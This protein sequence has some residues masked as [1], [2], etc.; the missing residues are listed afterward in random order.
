MTGLTLPGMM[1][2]PACFAGRLISLKPARGPEE[3]RRR[4]LQ[5]LDSLHATRLSTPDSCTKAPVS[6]VAS[7]M[8]GARSSVRPLAS[9]RCAH[10]SAQ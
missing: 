9:L 4:S 5:V 6:W 1:E 2:E 10:A 3:S 7:I 8:S